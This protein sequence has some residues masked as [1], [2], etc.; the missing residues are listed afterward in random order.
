MPS[1]LGARQTNES[2]ANPSSELF[3]IAH[4]YLA[5]TEKLPNEQLSLGLAS[6]G[7]YLALKGA[8]ESL[9]A[10]LNPAAVVEVRPTRH[11][12]LDNAR[13][14]ELRVRTDSSGELVLGYLGEVSA[15]G[16]A[17]FELR[18]PA[19]VAELNVL[20]LQKIANLVPQSAEMPTFPAITRD[21]NLVV[22]EAVRWADVEQTVRGA[23]GQFVEAIAFQD[24]Y[25][26]EQRLGP[27]KKSL[28][29]TLTLRSREG[30]LTGDHADRIR[31]D[32][33]TACGKA[34][35]AQFAPDSTAA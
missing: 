19:S 28:L 3:E 27:G 15:A 7:D 12:L 16:L 5:Q 20:A 1:L 18:S 21:L 14:A 24:V 30:T 13:S 10:V 32:V 35:G 22:D 17:R 29:L 9:L 33:V 23:A 6:G 11:E 8:I 26:D 31:A 2:L 4:V 25:R 34:H